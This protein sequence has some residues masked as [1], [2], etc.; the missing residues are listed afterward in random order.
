M[1]TTETPH[2]DH[3]FSAVFAS[4][5]FNSGLGFLLVTLLLS[6]DVLFSC[7]FGDW[8]LSFRLL[9]FWLCC[10]LF[11]CWFLCLL[12]CLGFIWF[13]CFLCWF[14]VFSNVEVCNNAC[15]DESPCSFGAAIALLIILLYFG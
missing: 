12:W 13:G 2:P 4:F 9:S 10:L 8:F 15:L 6:C 11:S 5:G 1:L 7:R 14:G 3:F